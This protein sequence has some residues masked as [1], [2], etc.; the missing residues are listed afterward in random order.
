[1]EQESGRFAFD[2]GV[3]RDDNVFYGVGFYAGNELFNVEL[4]GSDAVDWGDSAAEDV[5]SSG[6]LAR[7]FDGVNIERLFDDEDGGSIARG[8]GI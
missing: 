2:R 8:V 6:V 5:I 1:M 4:I 7:G 3:S